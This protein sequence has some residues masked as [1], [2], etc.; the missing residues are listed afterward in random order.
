[1]KRLM[2]NRLIFWNKKFNYRLWKSIPLWLEDIKVANERCYF[3]G[4]YLRPYLIFK[5]VNFDT[6]HM[7]WCE[8]SGEFTC[9]NCHYKTVFLSLKNKMEINQIYERTNNINL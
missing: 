8:P 1:M 6:R 9:S 7:N 2:L 3:C 5:K 4:W